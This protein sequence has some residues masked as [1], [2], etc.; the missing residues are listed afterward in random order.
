[1]PEYQS[2][3]ASPE[4]EAYLERKLRQAEELKTTGLP[5]LLQKTLE[6]GIL[7]YRGQRVTLDGRRTFR[8]V[9]NENMKTLADDL[10]TA[11]ELAAVKIERDE[12]IGT[13]LPW[14][15]GQL[16]A[17]YADLRLVDNQN[18]IRIEAPVT[19]RILEALRHRAQRPPEDRTGKA[20]T[21][22]FEAPPFGWDPRIVRLG[23][24]VLFKNGSIA[25]HLD[26]QD[27]DSPANPASHRAITDTRAF[28]RARFEL[29]QEVSP[30]DRDR[31]SRLLTQIFGVRGGNLLEEIETAL[32]QVVEVRA[33]AAREL[34]IRAEEQGLPV[35]NALQ[36]LEE[37]LAAIRRETN[38]SR[39]ILAFLGKAGVLEQR[40][41]LLVKLQTFDEQRG[42]KTYVRRRAF[43]F[44]VAPSWV[45]GNTQLEEQL[46][47]LQQNLQ[48]EDFLERWDTI[49]TDYRTLIGQYQATYTE[50]H[51]QRGE[52][53]Q[54]TIR[55]VETHPAWSKIE[56]A[57][58]EALLRPLNAL[59][60]AGSGTLAGE[61][62]R[63]GQCQA[64]FG[65]L[66]HALELIEPRQVAIERQLDEIPL[67]GG[68]RVEG[69]EDRRTLRSLED[70]DAM[71]RKLKD[72][73]RQ[74]AA[75]GKALNV[76]LKVEVTNG[77]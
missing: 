42:F 43:A 46:V 60:C 37:A 19:A 6:R 35:A 47:R 72:T 27:Y 75:Q 11:F 9:F 23:L 15:G 20:L 30:Q 21:D 61:E 53:V 65:D 41:P 12:H 5:E 52:A 31:A 38:R 17:I 3:R 73:A 71:A 59:A 48:A 36:E 2:G 69:Y 74:A 18:R 26:G 68:V 4:A 50:A 16:P 1:M 45:Q 55:Q 57:K 58:R 49:T 7:F 34:R 40:V 29:A 51:R 62:V 44:E 8:E 25:V 24:A 56:P 33:T 70:V 64:S 22:H 54:R 63:C 66:R 13:I 77:A 14:Q 67:P 76:T 32:V 28:T 10:F 39:R